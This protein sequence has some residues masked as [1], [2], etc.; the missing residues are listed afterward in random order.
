MW[1]QLICCGCGT[2]GDLFLVGKIHD[3]DADLDVLCKECRD[4]AIN[5]YLDKILSNKLATTL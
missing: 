3:E 1:E 2:T 4:V 5:N